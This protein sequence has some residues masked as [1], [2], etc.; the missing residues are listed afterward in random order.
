MDLLN[1]EKNRV[2][3]A[4]ITE[5]ALNQKKTTRN[6]NDQ[7]RITTTIILTS[8]TLIL[9]TVCMKFKLHFEN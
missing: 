8:L 5:M 2:V 7:V 6:C 3:L 1:S 9:M 4:N